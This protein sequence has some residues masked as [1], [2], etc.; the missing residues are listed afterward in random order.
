[1]I[2]PSLP[3]FCDGLHDITIKENA[4]KAMAKVISHHFD[5]SSINCL[6]ATL[7]TL[8]C[9]CL[10]ALPP[11]LLLSLE[12]LTNEVFQNICRDLARLEIQEIGLNNKVQ[13]WIAYY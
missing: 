12:S 4:S 2:C 5:L 3:I 10:R 13:R 8:F 6:T 7:D 1:M 9:C 11:S